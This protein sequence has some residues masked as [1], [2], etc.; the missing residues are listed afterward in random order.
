MVI[1]FLIS[2][3]VLT[4]VSVGVNMSWSM[5]GSQ[6]TSLDICLHVLPWLRQCLLFATVFAK[7]VDCQLLW[8]LSF[9]SGLAYM[10][11]FAIFSFCFLYFLFYMWTFTQDSHV[12]HRPSVSI[13]RNQFK[14]FFQE[15]LEITFLK[16]LS[17]IISCLLWISDESCPW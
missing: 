15:L 14:V 11:S 13:Q 4:C 7:L 3:Y 2:V 10:F 5:H 6:K 9:F 17:Q 16:L 1:L 12:E 8:I